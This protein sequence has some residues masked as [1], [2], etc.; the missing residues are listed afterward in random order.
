MFDCAF[1]PARGVRS[2]HYMGHIK[3]MGAVQ[4]FLS[5]AISK[6]VNVPKDAT[7]EEIEQAYIES[8]RLGA[9]AVSIYRDGCKRTQPLNTSTRQG[10]GRAAASPSTGP[11]RRKLPD[12]RARDHA[13][14]RHRRPRGLHHRRPLRGRHAGRD[15][16]GHG[17][18]R[19]DDL[20]LRRRVRA[21]DQLRAAVR[22]A[23][24]GPGRQVQPRPLRAVGH[25][26]EPGRPLR[27]VDR[28]LHLP[29]DGGEVPVA[30]SAVPR[31]RQ[32]PRGAGDD[33][34]AAAARRGRGRRARRRPA[35]IASP[36]DRRRSRR[37]RTRKTRR[38]A[39]RAA[40]SWCA[41]GSCYKCANCGTTS[42]CA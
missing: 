1:K 29:L 37:C 38:R 19:L 21:G 40:R 4:P 11:R 6:T 25:D 20:G 23:A 12:E 14:V 31:R 16:P 22:R 3:M 32:Q 7:V 34:G 41:A 36:N 9:K 42:G 26:Q 30:G 18:G 10:E 27:E 15:L 2:I 13:Q 28:R 35:A 17:E 33:A 8:W 39:R 24:A 5:G